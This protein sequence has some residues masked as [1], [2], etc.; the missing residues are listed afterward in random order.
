MDETAGMLK[1]D[2]EMYFNL[3]TKLSLNSIKTN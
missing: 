3:F 2:R 1:N